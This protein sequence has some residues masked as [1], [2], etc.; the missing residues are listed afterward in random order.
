MR[1][2]PDKPLTPVELFRRG[3][4]ITQEIRGRIEEARAYYLGRSSR[5]PA[6]PLSEVFDPTRG[7]ALKYFIETIR[8]INRT[9]FIERFCRTA[10]FRE[11]RQASEATLEELRLLAI[12]LAMCLGVPDKTDRRRSVGQALKTSVYFF[13]IANGRFSRQLPWN[14]S[15]VHLLLKNRNNDGLD[16]T[17][18]R[19][20]ECRDQ[21]KAVVV[22]L[23][24]PKHPQSIYHACERTFHFAENG[25]VDEERL[26]LWCHRNESR[27]WAW[28]ETYR[29]DHSIS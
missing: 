17:G 5:K 1:E 12:Q 4:E 14:G 6:Q 2:K 19:T 7:P 11:F 23:A 15:L 3:I 10:A 29:L 26:Y 9:R 16:I 28:V 13:R 20:P 22:W 18:P 24:N 25:Y 21:V 27:I 8:T